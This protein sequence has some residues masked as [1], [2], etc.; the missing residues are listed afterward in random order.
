MSDLA[1]LESAVTQAGNEV[2]KIKGEG[3]D[4]KPA[5][6]TL[7]AAKEAFKAALEKDIESL[8][9]GADE[10]VL[11]DLKKKL[12]SVTPKSRKEK[13]KKA[14]KDKEKKAEAQKPAANNGDRCRHKFRSRAQKKAISVKAAKEAMKLGQQT[15]ER[16]S[17]FRQCK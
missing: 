17:T 12:D 14:K 9:A 4:I 16:K 2:R 8:G 6:A 13:K 3:G 11:A 10:A 1:S 15:K 7:M 5:L